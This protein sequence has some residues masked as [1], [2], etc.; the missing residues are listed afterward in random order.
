MKSDLV[1]L[2]FL[3]KFVGG[4]LILGEWL[5]MEIAWRCANY[6]PVIL[7]S[8]IAM[9]IGGLIILLMGIGVKYEKSE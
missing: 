6:N 9:L 5:C 8:S 2:A 3:M 4:M 7:A 1:C